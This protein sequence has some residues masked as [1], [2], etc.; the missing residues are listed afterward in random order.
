LY[1]VGCS[2]GRCAYRGA[3]LAVARPTAPSIV[4]LLVQGTDGI[5]TGPDPE[6]GVVD[7]DIGCPRR[8]VSSE[9][10]VPGELFPSWSG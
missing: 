10:Q 2:A 6:N 8:P 4:F 9:L 7:P 1:A 5:P 3:A